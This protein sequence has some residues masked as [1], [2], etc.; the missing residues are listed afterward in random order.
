[1]RRYIT[2]TYPLEAIINY[3]PQ[4]IN[5]VDASHTSFVT[6]GTSQAN[7]TIEPINRETA[8]FL[9]QHNCYVF[10]TFLPNSISDWNSIVVGIPTS[11]FG[12]VSFWLEK[13]SISP[14]T[15]SPWWMVTDFGSQMPLHP[16]VLQLNTKGERSDAH[17]L[18][19]AFLARTV[20][21]VVNLET[22]EKAIKKT[23]EAMKLSLPS[24][25][26][27]PLLQ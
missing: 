25:N 17:L 3:A 6:S 12:T 16:A 9:G 13:R 26:F 21:K 4:T 1:M 27:Y 18:S 20:G 2:T 8:G 10:P 7:I 14:R 15:F 19:L 22:G 24:P 5:V 23:F 11:T